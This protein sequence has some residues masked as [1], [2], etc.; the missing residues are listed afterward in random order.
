M[1]NLMRMVM[2]LLLLT[3]VLLP[4][5][6]TLYDWSEETFRM[7]VSATGI[8]FG[9][10]EFYEGKQIPGTT[11]EYVLPL[12]FCIDTS[13]RYNV[14]RNFALGTDV[15]IVFEMQRPDNIKTVDSLLIYRLYP[16][17]ALEFIS[18]SVYFTD[19]YRRVGPQTPSL[20]FEG[21]LLLGASPGFSD[22][23]GNSFMPFLAFKPKGVVSMKNIDLFLALQFNALWGGFYKSPYKVLVC[24]LN[25]AFG[26][27]WRF[28]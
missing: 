25:A 26:I 4:S 6:S 12:S 15:D 2:T 17:L 18:K 1:K 10:V 7:S 24:T 14:T 21:A 22:N 16:A 19:E 11:T 5:Y 27:G 28:G 23:M 13:F 8:S 3:V 20:R 9:M